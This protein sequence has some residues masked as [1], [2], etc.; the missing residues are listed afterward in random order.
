MKI[1]VN[2]LLKA[3]EKIESEHDK[4]VVLDFLSDIAKDESGGSAEAQSKTG[5]D[6]GWIEHDG[7]GSRIHPTDT[8]EAETKHGDRL[9]RQACELQ[10]LDDGS[11]E[12]VLRY[13]RLKSG[14]W[15]A[16]SGFGNPVNDDDIVEA[17]GLGDVTYKGYAR[18]MIWRTKDSVSDIIRYKVLSP[19]AGSFHWQFYKN[20]NHVGSF[21][22]RDESDQCDGEWIEHDGG[23][24]P[25]GYYDPVDVQ[26]RGRACD[27]PWGVSASIP[28]VVRYR[29]L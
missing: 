22:D 11:Q 20:L 26:F 7:S 1:D 13:R 10:W 23:V 4:C 17:L 9:V 15:T 24:I 8:V 3:L 19:D 27:F 21:Q 12:V 18:D 6:D 28:H 16:Y 25:V 29:L 14:D 5:G 2:D